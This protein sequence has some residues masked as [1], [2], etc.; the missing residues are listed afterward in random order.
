MVHLI[1]E[2]S[3]LCMFTILWAFPI[4][5]A[6]MFRSNYYLWFFILSLIVNVGVFSHYESLEKVDALKNIGNNT[7][8]NNE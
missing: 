3:K 5:L 6:H 2:I 7:Q 8:K 4:V 1:R